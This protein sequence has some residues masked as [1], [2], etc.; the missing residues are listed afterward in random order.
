MIDQKQKS[1]AHGQFQQERQCGA[2]K[3][4]NCGL[5]PLALYCKTQ[6]IF[7]L[8]TLSLFGYVQVTEYRR[9]PMSA[10]GRTWAVLN[11]ARLPSVPAPSSKG[12]RVNSCSLKDWLQPF[13]QGLGRHYCTLIPIYNALVPNTLCVII[14]QLQY[15]TYASLV[16]FPLWRFNVPAE[17]NI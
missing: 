17:L 3:Y 12:A 15:G 1:E 9:Q 8:F 4:N 7:K 6:N 14:S 2:Q 11:T 13:T 16:C 10:L 5:C